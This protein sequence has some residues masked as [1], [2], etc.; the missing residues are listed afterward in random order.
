MNKAIL[1]GFLN[2]IGVDFSLLSNACTIKPTEKISNNTAAKI[3][4][5]ALSKTS[6]LN[7]LIF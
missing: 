1:N 3:G 4:K 6:N 2:L 5:K 7:L